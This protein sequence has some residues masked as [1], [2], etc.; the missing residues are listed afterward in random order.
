M[1]EYFGRRIAEPLDF[2]H[3]RFDLDERKKLP[4]D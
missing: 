2:D 1:A 3:T 4:T